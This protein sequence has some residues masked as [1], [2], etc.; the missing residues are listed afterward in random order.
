MDK[1]HL[2]SE[3]RFLLFVADRV[4][5]S[6]L[7]ASKHDIHAQKDSICL[8]EDL[9]CYVVALPLTAIWSLFQ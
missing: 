6:N 8:I 9:P 1:P 2:S 4:A 7:L 5:Y 3:S